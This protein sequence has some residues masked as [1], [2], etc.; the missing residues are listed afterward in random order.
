VSADL[1]PSDLAIRRLVYDGVMSNGAIPTQ[2]SLAS[3]A[4]MTVPAVS[5]ALLR[6]A[7]AH[8]LVLQRNGEILMANPFS[9]VATPFP[10]SIGNRSWYGNCI[11]DA[12]GIAAMMH[13]KAVIAASC[14]CCGTAMT[15]WVP[16]ECIADER[17]AHF[18]VPAAHWWDDIV[19]N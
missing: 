11:W 5:E 15:L 16:D 19:F 6:L 10:V 3:T 13:D 14:G 2:S 9:A 12:M 7:E 1:T 17:T 4:C 18:A 8:M